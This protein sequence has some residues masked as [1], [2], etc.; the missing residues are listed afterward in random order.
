MKS[1]RINK[2]LKRMLSKVILLS[3]LLLNATWLRIATAQTS[4][5]EQDSLALSA[6]YNSTDGQNWTNNANWLTGLLNSW[7][8]ITAYKV[9]GIWKVLVQLADNNLCGTIPTEIGDMIN[10]FDLDLSENNLTGPIPTTLSQLNNLRTLHLEN[11]Q[12]SGSISPDLYSLPNLYSLGLSGNRFTGQISSDIENLTEMRYLHLDDNQLSGS[13]PPQILNLQKLVYLHLENNYFNNLPDM[14]SLGSLRGL[15]IQNNQFTFEDI[16]PNISIPYFYY[17]PQDSIGEPIDTLINV[18]ES[19]TFKIN[20]GGTANQYQWV[21]DGI[22]IQVSLTNLFTLNSVS[23]ADSGIYYYRIKNSIAPDL[24][25][26]G[27]PIHLRVSGTTH[28]EDPRPDLPVQFRLYQNYPN[29]FNAVTQIQMDIPKSCDVTLQIYDLLG[30]KIATIVDEQKQP[31]NYQVKWYPESISS[32]IYF[33]QLKAG[34][35]VETK[36]LILQK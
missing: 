33:Y 13:I 7:Y 24:T 5:L 10:L 2:K 32:G 18:G 26:Y 30:K 17:S 12:L 23:L 9:S 36:K 15:H 4:P 8:G 11:N 6:L 19:I 27:R 1:R 21:K 29:P 31:G 28:I 25:L 34:D 14:S 35:F 20:S 22:I 3:L 16:E